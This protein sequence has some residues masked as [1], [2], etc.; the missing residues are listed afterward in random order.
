MITTTHG[1]INAVVARRR[2]VSDRTDIGDRVVFVIGGLAPDVALYL[3][4]LGA[5]IYYPIADGLSFADAHQRAMYDLYFN[6]SWWIAGHN[7][8]HAPLILLT[9]LAIASRLGATWSRRVRWFALGA[10]LH[11][12]IDVGVHHDDGPLVLF[13]LSWSY[14]FESPVSYWDPDHYGWLMRPIDLAITVAGTIWLVR[15]WRTRSAPPRRT[16]HSPS[17]SHR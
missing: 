10:L 15:W 12:V 13:P 1:V 6:S 11:A 17:E 14:R 2:G 8:F 3:L 5:L 4:N 7:L 9:V 16:Q